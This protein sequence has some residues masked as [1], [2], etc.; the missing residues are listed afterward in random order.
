MFFRIVESDKPQETTYFGQK[1]ILTII[2]EVW[3]SFFET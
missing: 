2:V 1:D 3:G